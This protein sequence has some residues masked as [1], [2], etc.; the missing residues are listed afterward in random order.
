[1][2]TKT[3]V[4]TGAS[5]GIGMEFARAFAKMGYSLILT[6]RRKDRLEKLASELSV[7]CEIVVSDLSNELECYQLWEKIS[8]RDINVFINNAGFGTCGNFQDTDLAKEVSMIN[9]NIR[10]YS[11]NHF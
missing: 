11:N 9:V 3:A 4:I 1:M 6:A 10:A 2:K 7:P 5:S 8:H